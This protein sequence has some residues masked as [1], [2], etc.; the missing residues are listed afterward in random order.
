[1]TRLRPRIVVIGAGIIGA[2][3]AYNLAIRGADVSLVDRGAQPGSGVT[4]RAFGWINVINGTPGDPSYALWREAMAE[5]SRLRADLPSGFVNARAGSLLWKA[6]PHETEQL[7]DLHLRAGENVELV[8]RN[9]LS[10]LEPS[11]TGVPDCAVF[12]RDDL[13]LDPAEL[14][15]ILVNSAVGAGAKVKLGEP[16]TAVQTTNGRIT[17]VRFSNHSQ[18]ADIVVVAA[19]AG[20]AAILDGLGISIGVKTS[21]ALLLQYSCSRPVIKHILRGPRLEIRQAPSNI[22][23]VAK[24][25]V[26]DGVENGPHVIGNRILATM[27]EE[28]DLPGDVA[29]LSADVGN[30][31]VFD[32]GLPR[33]G[34]SP[35]ISGLYVAAGHP[36]V[37]LAPLMGRLAAEELLEARKSALIHAPD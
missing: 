17:G 35:K 21:P 10:V 11:L 18:A 34:F 32:N 19:G 37:I 15:K 4:G 33:L 9:A 29:L 25:Y 20:T 28:L 22:L 14:A 7:A 26:E 5:F 13:A 2:A 3:V 31:P 23:V 24:S 8:G 27:T 6:T 16:I 36:G 30:R 1:M 12:S